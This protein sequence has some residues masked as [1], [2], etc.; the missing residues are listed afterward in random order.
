MANTHTH[1]IAKYFNIIQEMGYSTEE[2]MIELDKRSSF[3][4]GAFC[5][6]QNTL[7][8]MEWQHRQSTE[9]LLPSTTPGRNT[10]APSFMKRTDLQYCRK[11]KDGSDIYFKLAAPPIVFNTGEIIMVEEVSRTHFERVNPAEELINS[12]IRLLEVIINKETDV[13]CVYNY[14]MISPSWVS[15]NVAKVTGRSVTETKETTESTLIH[16]EDLKSASRSFDAE[17]QLSP[18]NARIRHKNGQ[19]EWYHV[20]GITFSNARKLTWSRKVADG[21]MSAVER[22]VKDMSSILAGLNVRMADEDLK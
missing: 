3:Q 17:G 14:G 21:P 15:Q 1:M 16:P 12:V 19:Y 10:S 11:H 7:V 8:L 2:I 22:A 18:Y 6:E 13:L 5:D 4:M 20:D 9:E